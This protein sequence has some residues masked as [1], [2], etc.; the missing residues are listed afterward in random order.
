MS[1]NLCLREVL[2]KYSTHDKNQKEISTKGFNHF[3]HEKN[4]QINS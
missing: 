1:H 3:I 2:E 4:V